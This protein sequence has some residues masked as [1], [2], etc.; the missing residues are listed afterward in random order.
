MVKTYLCKKTKEKIII[1]GDL[2]KPI[3]SKL[4]S[5]GDLTFPWAKKGDFKQKTI[6]KLTWDDYNLYAGY[7]AYDFDIIS[8]NRGTKGAVYNDDV[9]EIFI[10]PNPEDNQYFGFEINARGDLLDYIMLFYRNSNRNWSVKGLK[11]AIQIEGTLNN[12]KDK[13]RYWTLE[14][15]IPWKNFT[16]YAKTPPRDGDIWKIA[17]NRIDYNIIKGKKKEEYSMWSPSRAPVPD[18]HLRSSF[19]SVIFIK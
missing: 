6:I 19:G 2:N 13:D 11:Y 10:D 15:A 3:W 17:L 16:E 4:K 12:H 5:V 14:L 1:N 7:L 9:L 8:Q 18:Y